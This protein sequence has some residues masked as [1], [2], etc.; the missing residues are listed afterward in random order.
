M[1][2]EKV[3][4]DRGHLLH[5]CVFCDPNRNP[6]SVC[7]FLYRMPLILSGV[8]GMSGRGVLSSGL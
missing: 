8:S 6:Q 7:V 3:R 4:D 1:Q 5:K 2:L